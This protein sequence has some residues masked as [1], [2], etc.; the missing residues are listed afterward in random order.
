YCCGL[1]SERS[2]HD[3]CIQ[4][5][6]KA[7]KCVESPANKKTREISENDGQF[8]KDYIQ[9]EF[10]TGDGFSSQ[11]PIMIKNVSKSR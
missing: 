6:L 3:G 8:T 7:W 5:K 2:C 9:V 4:R 10:P 1:Y 11:A